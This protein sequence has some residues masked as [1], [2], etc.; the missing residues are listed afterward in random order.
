MFALERAESPDTYKSRC[1]E[2]E[3]KASDFALRS[4]AC[5]S[6]SSAADT[7]LEVLAQHVHNTFLFLSIILR[8]PLCTATN[9]RGGKRLCKYALQ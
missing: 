6:H 9:T 8:F 5:T 7:D 1:F 4:F 3:S 2:I